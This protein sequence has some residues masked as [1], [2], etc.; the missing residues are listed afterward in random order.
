MPCPIC[1]GRHMYKWCDSP[2]IPLIHAQGVDVFRKLLQ[3]SVGP[4]HPGV[5]N[6]NHTLLRTNLNRWLSSISKDVARN[7][8]TNHAPRRMITTIRHNTQYE[9]SASLGELRDISDFATIN[10]PHDL[11]YLRLEQ[12]RCLLR[13]IYYQLALDDIRQ[14]PTNRGLPEMASVSN[15]RG[16]RSI[17][18]A[19]ISSINHSNSSQEDFES[20][21]R[22]F[23]EY[24]G[25]LT[26]QGGSSGNTVASSPEFITPNYFRL[27]EMPI[28]LRNNPFPIP[29]AITN[30]QFFNIELKTEIPQQVDRSTTISP[31]DTSSDCGICWDPLEHS[32]CI[33]TNCGHAFCTT[34]I[35]ASMKATK[36]KHRRNI[37]LTLSCAMCR[38]H[39]QQLI[40]SDQASNN[41]LMNTQ[42]T[43]HTVNA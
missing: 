23:R 27:V 16:I 37:P 10:V 35:I 22:L 1:G 29:R 34:C 20:N 11:S 33:T 3:Y 9:N 7:L 19:F 30:E 26:P 31:E 18:R 28:R 40:A 12:L 5:E 4:F 14:D 21:L 15:M 42:Y 6:P 25:D 38:G 2:A 17:A 32:N 8:V 43:T 41:L 13:A 39:V 24:V 36:E